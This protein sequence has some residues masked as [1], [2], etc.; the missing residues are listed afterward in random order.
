M[1]HHAAPP[2]FAMSFTQEAVQLERRKG[3]GWTP[4]GH[5]EFSRHDLARTLAAMHRK[6]GGMAGVSDTLLVIPDDQILYTTLT[7]P[8]G[9]DTAATI[10]KALESATPYAAE[11]LTFDWCPATNGDIETL[12]VAAVAIRTLEEAEEFARAQGFHPSGFIGRPGDDRFDGQPDF[13]TARAVRP[14]AAR[15]FSQ[16]DLTQA[17]V[18]APAIEIAD[19]A[20]ATP[21]PA[22]PGPAVVPV[23]S[24]IVP[25]YFAQPAAAQMPADTAPAEVAPKVI[26]HDGS[27]TPRA[28]AVHDRAAAARALRAERDAAGT[29]DASPAVA[30]I[31]NRFRKLD[32]GRLPVMIG[33]LGVLLLGG[34][35]FFG[36]APPEN[37]PGDA[38]ET[39]AAPEISEEVPAETGALPDVQSV[40]E[41]VP[42]VVTETLPEAALEPAPEP[43]PPVETADAL[44]PEPAVLT[45]EAVAAA[46]A[47]A[48]SL[49]P[50]PETAGVEPPADDALTQALAEAMADPEA[51][52]AAPA[53]DQPT[54]TETPTDTGPRPE[55]AADEPAVTP[56]Q[57]R[58]ATQAS[59]PLRRS[60]RPPRTAPVA[61]SVPAAP[62]SR[63]AVPANP[64]PYETRT[65]P[66]ARN[67]GDARPPSR[68]AAAPAPAAPA[69][70]PAAP[71][72]A[73]VPA[74]PAANGATTA[75]PP[76]PSRSDAAPAADPAPVAQPQVG[77]ARPPSRPEEGSRAEADAPRPLTEEERADVERQLRG[78]RTAQAGNVGL[79]QG[80]RGL[81]I[82]LADAR[83]MRR[84]TSVSAP[85]QR[86]VTDALAAAQSDGV[87]GARP[88]ERD[89]VEPAA[90]PS[91][92]AT[93]VAGSSRPPARPAS[94]NRPTSPSLSQDA[95]KDAL[96]SAIE[97]SPA[98]PGGIALTTLSSSA[99]PPRRAG[100]AVASAATNAIAASAAPVAAAAA[101]TAPS[102]ADLRAAA[103]AQAAQAEQR[104]AD[105][106]LQR[107]AEERARRQAA[108]DA[109]AEAQARAA[110]EARARAQAEAEARA[111]AARNQRYRPAEVD[112]EPDVVAAVPQSAVGSASASATV[113]DGIR[114]NSTQIIGTIGAGRASRALVRLSNG[115]VIT[116]RIGDKINGGTITEIKDSRILY[117]KRGQV[118]A[119]GVLN[120]Q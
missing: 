109:A 87:A 6:A 7:V 37:A 110:A 29:G 31:A 36:S 34:M 58:A 107:Q 72:P 12:R 105:D 25:H 74:T 2:E 120:G 101:A 89:T 67:V 8:F 93:S 44:P 39:A 78:F 114:L 91:G 28:A 27:L 83:P 56:A 42:A 103:E 88:P 75:R 77:G 73:P 32:F 71:A 43:A 52:D 111:A 20:P 51:A 18:T 9:S 13:G 90:R 63:P 97:D 116:L 95:V 11:E 53:A 79:S 61:A 99:K 15:P 62:D 5:A 54:D 86:A 113:K 115:R 104:R 117:N 50:Q 57:T 106:E 40:P 85:S 26:R 47:I 84:P 23:I 16:P 118:Q 46:T 17:R 19:E 81:L 64:L 21:E 66:P 33:G 96:A 76:S 22:T 1:N 24:A 100:G 69:P 60:A 59:T 98:R 55:V 3:T 45:P 49:V 80:E 70:T 30:A 108:A 41:S 14:P 65:A 38:T 119:L 82:Q 112:E 68:P 92:P 35:L 10:A 4:V 94:A 48:D 102:A